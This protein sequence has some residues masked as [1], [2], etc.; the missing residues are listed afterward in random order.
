MGP[1]L[2]IIILTDIF[3]FFP[4]EIARYADDNTSHAMRDCLKKVEEASNTLFKFFSNN[5]MVANADKCHLLTSTSGEVIIKV[6]NEIIK[7]FS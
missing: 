1:L 6:E 2:F 5:N 7:N 3:R 4:T